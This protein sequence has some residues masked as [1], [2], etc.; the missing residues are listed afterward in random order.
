MRLVVLYQVNFTYHM[1]SDLYR[2][3]RGDADAAIGCREDEIAN[4]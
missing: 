3:Y 4:Q 1:Q 2:V